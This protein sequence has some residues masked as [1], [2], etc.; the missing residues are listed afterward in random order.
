MH[1]LKF[2]AVGTY[3]DRESSLD[4]VV[5]GSLAVSDAMRKYPGS[6]KP[7]ETGFC[8]GNKT[9]LRFFQWLTAHPSKMERFNTALQTMAQS[10]YQRIR[11]VY[12]W[13]ALGKARVVDLGG[14]G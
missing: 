14:G 12:P 3:T 13:Q 9:E 8:V 11:K 7:E 1:T 4:V 5:Q 2:H 10:S 6:T